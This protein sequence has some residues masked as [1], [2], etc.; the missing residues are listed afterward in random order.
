M[1]QCIRNLGCLQDSKPSYNWEVM[2]V[3]SR[4]TVPATYNKQKNLTLNKTK[5]NKVG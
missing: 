1:C 2:E 5:Y 3:L 4:L